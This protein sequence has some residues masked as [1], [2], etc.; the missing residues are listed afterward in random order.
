MLNLHLLAIP[1]SITN[2]LVIGIVSIIAAF[3]TLY[4]IF[5]RYT[6]GRLEETKQNA[7]NLEK[8][9]KLDNVTKST[10]EDLD[11]WKS[12]LEALKNKQEVDY[13]Y[14][15]KIFDNLEKDF[16]YY[17]KIIMENLQN[18]KK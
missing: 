3:V 16:D 13:E 14:L 10:K 12:V 17:R 4:K 11:K 6:K 2:D 15:T 7:F 18:P 5:D 1:F 9:E 8:M